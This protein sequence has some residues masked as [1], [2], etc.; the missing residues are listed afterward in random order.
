MLL[1]TMNR[2]LDMASPM[3]SSLLTLVDL[4]WSKSR[5]LGFQSLLSR[6][7]VELGPMLLLTMN[8]KP[9]VA[10]PM[11]SLLTL[12]DPDRSKS[13]SLGLLSLISHKGV[14]LGPILLLTMNRKPF[15]ASSMTSL[16]TLSDR[17]RSNSR[18][19]GL[20]CLISRNRAELGPMLLL[21]INVKPYMETLYITTFDLVRHWKAKVK[22]THTSAKLGH[23]LPYNQPSIGNHIWPVQWHLDIWHWVT[24]KG[25]GH[26]NF[27]KP[28]IS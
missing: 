10:S 18:S 28:Y 14:E 4:E 23:M 16:L 8:R 11:T 22:V 26:L 13:R 7:G 24:L 25:Q 21:T 5:S 3:T 17:E 6:K 9:Y 15:M 27:L 19:L 20:Q 12:S 2:K 1:L